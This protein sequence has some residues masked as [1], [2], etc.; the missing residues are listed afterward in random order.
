MCRTYATLKDKF[1]QRMHMLYTDTDSLILQFFTPD[2][3]G[4]LLN[5]P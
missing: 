5:V 1:I 2:L 3:Y 4:E